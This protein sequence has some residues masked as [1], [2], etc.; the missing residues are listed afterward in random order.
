MR[1]VQGSL[2]GASFACSVLSIDLLAHALH[3]G[4]SQT[5]LDRLLLQQLDRLTHVS[6]L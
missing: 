4:R 2:T 1:S 3:M 5:G 6:D